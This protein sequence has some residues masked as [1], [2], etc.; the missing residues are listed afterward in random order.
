[1]CVTDGHDMTLAV[2]VVLNPNLLISLRHYNSHITQV[3]LPPSAHG[4]SKQQERGQ[5][6]TWQSV[7]ATPYPLTEGAAQ[8]IGSCANNRSI[9]SAID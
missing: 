5:L 9:D 3:Y 8:S 7:L 6:D 1:M 4:H 2:R